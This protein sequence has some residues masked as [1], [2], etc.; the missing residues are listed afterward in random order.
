MRTIPVLLAT[1][2][3]L[4]VAGCSSATSESSDLTRQATGGPTLASS[5]PGNASSDDIDRNAGYGTLP[6]PQPIIRALGPNDL[7]DGF[8]LAPTAAGACLAN[9]QRELVRVTTAG[10]LIWQT[11]VPSSQLTAVVDGRVIAG[12]GGVRSGLLAVD[13]TSGEPL[14]QVYSDDRR[15]TSLFAAGDS[16]VVASDTPNGGQLAGIDFRTGASM[17]TVEFAG[18]HMQTHSLDGEWFAVVI[19]TT[20]VLVDKAGQQLWE[21]DYEQAEFGW[22]R[23]TVAEEVVVVSDP[24]TATLT[25][26]DALTGSELWSQDFAADEVALKH[27]S[28]AVQPPG[29]VFVTALDLVGDSRNE[30]TVA[31]DLSTGE[32]RWRRDSTFFLRDGVLQ[33]SGTSGPGSPGEVLAPDG[34]VAWEVPPGGLDGTADGVVMMSDGVGARTILLA[35]DGTVGYR[36]SEGRHYSAMA[37]LGS[38]LFVGL[39]AHLRNSDELV[40][41][42]QLVG[43]DVE[44]KDERF[45]LELDA[46]LTWTLTAHPNDDLIGLLADD[47]NCERYR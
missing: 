15:P 19:D 28:V 36:D 11:T 20:L 23:A 33:P 34:S 44:S 31:F 40:G 18:E 17:W 2:M 22:L 39:A 9:T 41:P 47:E 43:I 4:L 32:E 38:T 12:F 24:A 8:V 37:R 30:Q 46:P 42:P 26:F 16:L 5:V 7:A 29:W 25:A 10:E 13:D 27:P 6:E 14:W 21:R 35:A 1:A 3:L 45:R